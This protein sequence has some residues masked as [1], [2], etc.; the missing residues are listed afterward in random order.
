MK[1]NSFYFSIFFVL[2]FIVPSSCNNKQPFKPD[3]KTIGGVVIGKESCNTDEDNDYWLIDFTVYP[4]EPPHIGDTL[5]LNGMTYT[6][7]LKVKGLQSRLKYVGMEVAIDYNKIGNREVTMGCT[8]DSP[9]VYNLKEI[10]IIY[11]FEIR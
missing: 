1:N 4:D 5:E 8:V 7:V 6:N 10:F 2:L 11:Q 9:V 3:Y